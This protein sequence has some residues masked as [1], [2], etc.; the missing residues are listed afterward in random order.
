MLERWVGGWR[1]TLGLSTDLPQQQQQQ[2]Q[3]Q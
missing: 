1:A 2:Q 3:Q